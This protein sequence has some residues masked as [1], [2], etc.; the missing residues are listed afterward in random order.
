MRVG[1]KSWAGSSGFWPLFLV[2]AFVV[3]RVRYY[4][5]G[6]RFDAS[7]LGYYLQYI[8]PPLLQDSLL[9][10]VFY[11]HGQPPLFNLF[12]GVVLKLFPSSYLLAFAMIYMGLGLTLLLTTYAVLVRTGVPVWLGA[13]IALVFYANPVTILYE[14]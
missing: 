7:P 6:V 11:L 1:L 8:D 4:L 9:E 10:S 5:A 13:V 14:N 3:S 12:L 2:V